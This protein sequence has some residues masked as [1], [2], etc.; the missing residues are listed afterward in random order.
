[1]CKMG[2]YYNRESQKQVSIKSILK[3]IQN[4]EELERFTATA[5]KRQG[6]Y[7]N[8]ILNLCP[9]WPCDFQFAISNKIT[10]HQYCIIN[11]NYCTYCTT[12]THKPWACLHLQLYT[13][14]HVPEIS[15][16]VNKYRMHT[17]YKYKYHNYLPDQ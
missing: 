7:R 14:I 12:H 15:I 10:R 6:L 5:T 1:M 16:Y 2:I 9:T 13:C 11:M 3:M 17:V 8:R 4:Q